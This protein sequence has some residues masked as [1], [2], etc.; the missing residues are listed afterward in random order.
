MSRTIMTEIMIRSTVVMTVRKRG[1]ARWR[2]GDDRPDRQ[3][4]A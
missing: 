2:L 3:A 1:R 4:A